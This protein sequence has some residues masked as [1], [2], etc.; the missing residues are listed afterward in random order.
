MR[1]AV[2]SLHSVLHSLGHGEQFGY[3]GKA[4]SAV[5]LF[6][7]HI[8]LPFS[9]GCHLG[10]FPFTAFPAPFPQNPA[11]A[12]PV[13]CHMPRVVN[14]QRPLF[15]KGSCLMRI[16]IYI[17]ICIDM[18]GPTPHPTTFSVALFS[19][20]GQSQPDNYVVWLDESDSPQHP[21]PLFVMAS[22]RRQSLER[23][24]VKHPWNRQRCM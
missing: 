12:W 23:K 20:E 11:V 9:L 7:I 21:L 22:A 17:Y 16:H 18:P 8:A 14:L 1:L 6:F 10:G 13:C 15:V 24:C 3:A 4:D 2:V 5:L 19:F